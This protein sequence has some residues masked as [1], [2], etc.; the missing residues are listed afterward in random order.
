MYEFILWMCLQ[1]Q[2]DCP[3][4]QAAGNKIMIFTA[5]SRADCEAQWQESLK[6]PDPEGLKS[7]HRC[8][9]VSEPL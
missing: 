9:P 5:E 3:V 6:E 8:Q 1:Q 4:Y 2:P 7:Y